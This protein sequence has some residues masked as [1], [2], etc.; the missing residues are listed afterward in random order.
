ME[1]NKQAHS[2]SLLSREKLEISGVIEVLS[3]TEKEVVIK[4]SDAFLHVFGDGLKIVKLS[5]EDGFA[6][7]KGRVNGL[8]Y[9]NKLAK[10]TL[11]GR[12]FK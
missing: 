1:E 10:K 6:V 5:P 2:L 9:E 11:L 8:Q 3:S 4:L 12:V 7:C